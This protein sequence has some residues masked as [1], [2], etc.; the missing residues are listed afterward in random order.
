MDHGADMKKLE[1]LIGKPDHSGG[2]LVEPGKRG[3]SQQ[4]ELDKLVPR[5][6][7]ILVKVRDDLDGLDIQWDHPRLSTVAGLVPDLTREKEPSGGHHVN[8]AYLVR[9]LLAKGEYRIELDWD[10]SQNGR[11]KKP[12]RYIDVKT[13]EVMAFEFPD[14]FHLLAKMGDIFEEVD[15]MVAPPKPAPVP[16]PEKPQPA[17]AKA[18]PKPKRTRKKSE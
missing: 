18:E 2:W 6:G 8:Y 5:A 3:V 17:F 7:Y 14:A 9:D 10:V 1:P 12:I 13:K 11:V 15:Q 4:K 16:E